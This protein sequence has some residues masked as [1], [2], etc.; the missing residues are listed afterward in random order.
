[1]KQEYADELR[2][3]VKLLD[4]EDNESII[5]GLG[6]FKDSKWLTNVKKLPNFDS[7][8]IVDIINGEYNNWE[9]L[10]FFLEYAVDGDI[11]MYF[12]DRADM[13]SGLIHG[14]LK[15]TTK[16]VIVNILEDF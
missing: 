9:N 5:L 13:V 10:N 15:G 7:L 12:G 11:I 8:Q 3:I 16:I 4:S 6:M 14:M 1:M 2:E